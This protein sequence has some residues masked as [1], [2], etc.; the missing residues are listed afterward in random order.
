VQQEPSQLPELAAE[1]SQDPGS[2]KMGGDLGFF[3]RGLMVK[4]FED[5]V[6]QMELDEIRGL[7]ETPFGFHIVKLTAIREADTADFE[8]VRDHVEQ[9]LK[10]Q[11]VAERFG[12]LAE[13]FSNIVYEQSDTLQLAAEMFNLPIQQSDWLDRK[14][15]EPE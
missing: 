4:A 3:S 11:K 9:Q 13:D 15:N 2:A 1:L 12:E 7:V 10:Y 5:E 8:D 14:S 6:F